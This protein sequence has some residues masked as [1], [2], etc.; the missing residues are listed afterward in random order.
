MTKEAK[1]LIGISALVIAGGVVLSIVAN[2]KP[3]EPGAP[4]DQQSLTRETSHLKGSKDAKVKVVEFADFQCPAC[5]QAQGSMGK[6][7]ED[8]KDNP[9]VAFI[10]RNFPLDQLHRNAR[11]AAEFAEAAGEQGKFWELVPL[12]YATQNQWGTSTDP[13]PILASQAKTLGLD[14][15]KIKASVDQRKF[16]D[17]IEEDRKDGEAAGVKGTPA[18]FINGVKSDSYQYDKL[19]EQIEAELAKQ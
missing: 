9:N 17:V 8:Y 1:I 18:I 2:P 7:W 3:K 12:V 5:A 6:L 16:K 13:F 19:K 10:F 4:V 11:V 14:I 15:D